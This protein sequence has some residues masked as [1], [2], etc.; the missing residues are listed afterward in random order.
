MVAQFYFLQFVHIFTLSNTWLGGR[1]NKERDNEDRKTKRGQEGKTPRGEEEK[2]ERTR[3]QKGCTYKELHPM[4]QFYFLPPNTREIGNTWLGGRDDK[5]DRKT[6]RGQE[7]KT[8]RGRVRK[9][10][11]TRKHKG[12]T[13]K[14]LHRMAHFILLPSYTRNWNHLAGWMGQQRQEN[15]ERA[16]RDYTKRRGRKEGKD[17]EA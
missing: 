4:A 6:K 5:E 11:R 17:K 13:Y 1:D 16:G 10:K 14:E 3:K 8:P 12:G 7:G 2:R 15:K 9:K